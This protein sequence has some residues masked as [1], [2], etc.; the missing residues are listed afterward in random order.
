MKGYKFQSLR[1]RRRAGVLVAFILLVFTVT[2]GLGGIEV[3]A[4]DPITNHLTGWP[5]MTDIN[6]SSAVL[7]DADTGAV[8]YSL[9][10]GEQ[11]YPASITKIMTC[12]LAIEKGDLGETV[13]MTEAGLKEAYLGSS[14]IVPVL[15]EEFTLEQC[16]YMLM[17]K[18]ANDIATELAVHFGGSVE[19]FTDMMN[20]RAAEMG[21][22]GTHFN[23][24]NGLP[25][26]NHYTTAYDMG[27]IMMNCI[28]NET[29]RKILGT[30]VYTVPPTNK[31]ATER[32]YQNHCKLIIEGTEFYYE[33][34]LGGKTGYTDSAWRTLVS[35]AEKDG[36]TLVCVTM[37]GPDTTDFKDHKA[38]F[39]YG[40]N[41]FSH[42]S[43]G[44]D[45][46]G[47][48]AG[49]VT[50]PS[51]VSASSLAYSDVTEGAETVR[52]YTYEDNPV[53]RATVQAEAA[54]GTETD[55]GDVS[56]PAGAGTQGEETAAGAEQGTG[57]GKT[58]RTILFA[59]IF[60]VVIL[61]LLSLSGWIHGRSVSR[62]KKR[63]RRRRS[64]Q[65]SGS[66]RE[67]YDGRERT[68]SGSRR[69]RRS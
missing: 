46:G 38:L 57:S 15:G 31:T 27:L 7:M 43:V 68:R 53:G 59:L 42:V 23:N 2:S 10:R 30:S 64:G 63:R 50:L 13:T 51:S 18:S 69:R 4:S 54:T 36:M 29:F 56:A 45:S 8:L 44:G 32:I 17:L 14:N 9:N 19:G 60:S 16:L 49:Q 34:C 1:A 41:N 58:G 33:N 21:C 5:S 22:T 52:Y 25:D 47:A 62:R 40:F 39:E 6:E 24:A 67:S 20:A 3:M 12:L 37:H 26:T 35:A 11:R 66:R 65:A 55:R 61:G 48:S 28:R